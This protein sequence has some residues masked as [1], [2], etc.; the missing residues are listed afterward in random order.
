MWCYECA[1]VLSDEE[2]TWYDGR[3][4]ECEREWFDAVEEWRRGAHNLALDEMYG[5]TETQH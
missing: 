1:A 3:C 5:Q 2:T 4:E